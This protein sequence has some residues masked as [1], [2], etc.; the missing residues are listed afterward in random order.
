M[1]TARLLSLVVVTVLLL[2][3]VP[4]GAQQPVAP[5][6]PQIPYGA[7]ISLEQAKKVMAGA[8]A[9]A[10]KHKWNMVIAVLDSGGHLVMLER[11]DGTQLGSIGAAEDKAYSAVMY[12]RPTKVFQDHVVQGG[13][14]S[15]PLGLRGSS[16]PA[17]GIRIVRGGQL[18]GAI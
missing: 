17:G 8:E 15:R 14:N 16:V 12:R 13:A 2:A 7:P 3:C 18:V 9:E 1:R 5:P 6:P 4:V 10:Y 11:M